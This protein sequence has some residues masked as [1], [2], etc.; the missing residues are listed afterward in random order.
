MVY[1]DFS[2]TMNDL[3]TFM[4]VYVC[5]CVV[6]VCIDQLE[7]HDQTQILFTLFMFYLIY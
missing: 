2:S 6:C 1:V 4:C 3:S 7:D 5:V